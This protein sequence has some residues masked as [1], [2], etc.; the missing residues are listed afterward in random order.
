MIAETPVA[1][2][3][4]PSTEADRAADQEARILLHDVSPV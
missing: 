1:I 2:A 3:E 4:R